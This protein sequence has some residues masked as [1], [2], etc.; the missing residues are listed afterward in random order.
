MKNTNTRQSIAR[1]IKDHRKQYSH[2]WYRYFFNNMHLN[3]PDNSLPGDGYYRGLTQGK[4]LIWNSEVYNP[5]LDH[6]ETPNFE[7]HLRHGK[8]RSPDMSERKWLQK[9][10]EFFATVDSVLRELQVDLTVLNDLQRAKR[11]NCV[12]GTRCLM[13]RLLP[14]YIRLREIGYSHLDLTT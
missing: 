1:E 8:Q 13:R 3:L 10:R 7:Y 9:P 12:E 5:L 4:Y 14:V 6:W 2:R 11:E